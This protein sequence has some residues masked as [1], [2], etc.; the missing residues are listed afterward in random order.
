M[1]RSRS[2]TSSSAGV[3]VIVATALVLTFVLHA[4]SLRFTMDDTYISLRYARNLVEGHGLVFNPGERVRLR[5]INGSAMTMEVDGQASEELQMPIIR[6]LP[7]Q[8]GIT[9]SA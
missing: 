1:A 3:A 4:L 6:P 9:N 7:C 8:Q 5:V 2:K